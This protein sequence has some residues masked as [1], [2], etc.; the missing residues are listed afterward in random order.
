MGLFTNNKKL[1]PICGSPT[2]RLLAT[3]IEDMPIC[4][5]WDRKIDL[6]DG[7]TGQMSLEAFRQYIAFYEENSSLRDRFTETQR[8]DYPFLDKDISLDSVHGLFRLNKSLRSFRIVEDR[9]P[10][11]EGSKEALR[12]YESDVPWRVSSMQADIDRFMRDRREYERMERMTRM[13]EQQNRDRNQDR[14]RDNP[15]PSRPYIPEPRFE[16]S[17]PI[18]SLYM[19][20][21]MEHP[22]WTDCRMEWDAPSFNS[23]YPST[24]DYLND[25]R[26]MTDE[27]YELARGLMT[28]L[29]PGA[30][31]QY[32]GKGTD[33]S[34][35][36]DA[37]DLSVRDAAGE[38]R[39]FKELLD[40]GIITDEEFTAKKRQ[41]LGI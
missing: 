24:E 9:S 27:L 39:K 4:K 31:E 14:D 22:Y 11:F 12:C 33:S 8:Y 41:L 15:P 20:I 38:I 26:E 25:Y 1:C 37:E 2:P 35:S 28:L 19:E 34:G 36:K 5:E 30:P 17:G 6:P 32:I 40:A 3:K 23:S 21:T 10:L 29:S 13:M 7:L 16:A 18:H